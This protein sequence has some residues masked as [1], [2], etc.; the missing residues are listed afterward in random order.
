MRRLWQILL[1]AG[2]VLQPA[3]RQ[4]SESYDAR[5][6]ANSEQAR[7]EANQPSSTPA[8]R[9]LP[10]P[11]L[12]PGDTLEVTKEDIC[13]PGYS[14]KVRDVPE[15]LKRKVYAEYGITTHRPRE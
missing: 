1:V 6:S 13:V 7:K 12:T 8:T 2:F 14:S 11:Q 15:D 10:D 4:L 5:T 3:C 9:D